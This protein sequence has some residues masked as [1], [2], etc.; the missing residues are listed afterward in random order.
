M[1]DYGQM[2]N[3]AEEPKKRTSCCGTNYLLFGSIS[4][5]LSQE[6]HTSTEA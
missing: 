5:V 6:T 4:G 1:H 3:F 2:L